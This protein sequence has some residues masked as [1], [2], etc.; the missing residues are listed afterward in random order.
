MTIGLSFNSIPEI[1]ALDSS[2]RPKVIQHI[3]GHSEFSPSRWQIAILNGLL[4]ALAVIA[5]RSL[6]QNSWIAW[7]L[8]LLV[9]TPIWIV[10]RLNLVTNVGRFIQK[11]GLPSA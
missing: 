6:F 3:L 1:Q 9:L 4:A 11:H 8:I 10:L 2:A 7:P 5:G